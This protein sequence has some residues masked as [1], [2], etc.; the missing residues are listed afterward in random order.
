V[1]QL[2]FSDDGSMPVL[3]DMPASLVTSDA[4]TWTAWW[5]TLHVYGLKSISD[6][7]KLPP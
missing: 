2:G 1:T 6:D 7:F 4:M 5:S 3:K